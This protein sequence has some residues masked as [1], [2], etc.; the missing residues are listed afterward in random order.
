VCIELR[1]DSQQQLVDVLSWSRRFVELA[2]TQTAIG[3]NEWERY[4][5]VVKVKVAFASKHSNL[6]KPFTGFEVLRIW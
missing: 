1:S 5:D 6:S 3:G 2:S 4:V